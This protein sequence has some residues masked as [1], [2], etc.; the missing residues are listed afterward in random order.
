[1]SKI[2]H[3]LQWKGNRLV[4]VAALGFA[5]WTS[6]CGTAREEN[7][8]RS[9][10]FTQIAAQTNLNATSDVNNLQGKA[11]YTG[12]AIANFGSFGGTADMTLTAD[13]DAQAITGSMTSWEDLSPLTHILRGQVQLSNGAIANDGSFTSNMAGNI[14]RNPLGLDD[15]SNQPI[16]KVFNGSANGQIYDSVAGATASHLNGSFG[17]IDTG[18]G[19]I[20]GSFVAKR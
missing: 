18:G 2:L 7:F 3:E 12:A 8:D 1:M 17:G 20:D 19:A 14:E 10:L 11:T 9:N 13:F 4:V 16:L 15:P 5:A 6:G